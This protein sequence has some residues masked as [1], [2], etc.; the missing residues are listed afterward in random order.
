MN[1]SHVREN[2]FNVLHTIFEP[3]SVVKEET[4]TTDIVFKKNINGRITAVTVLSEKKKALTLKS[5]WIINNSG[6]H[7]PLANVQALAPTS[8]TDS[9]TSTIDKQGYSQKEKTNSVSNNSISNKGAKSNRLY[10]NLQ[11]KKSIIAS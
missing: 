1:P 7:T 2:V 4:G 11:I 10:K 6:R 5:A 3:D 8:K 9:R